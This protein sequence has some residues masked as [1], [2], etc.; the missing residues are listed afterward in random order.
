LRSFTGGLT[1][2]TTAAKLAGML[3][4]EIRDHVRERLP[5]IVDFF[6]FTM[7]I[8]IITAVLLGLTWLYVNC[9]VALFVVAIVVLAIAHQPFC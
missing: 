4:N 8:T 5:A 3:C 9:G 2:R 7:A 6:L 1:P